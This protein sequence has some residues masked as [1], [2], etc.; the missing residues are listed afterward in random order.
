MCKEQVKDAKTGVTRD[1]GYA[2]KK[3][4]YCTRHWNDKFGKKAVEAAPAATTSTEAAPVTTNKAPGVCKGIVNSTKKPCTSKAKPGSEFCGRHGGNKGSGTKATPVVQASAA[5]GEVGGDSQYPCPCPCITVSKKEQCPKIAYGPGPNGKPACSFHKGPKK[6]ETAAGK[7][8]AR[9][10]TA[11][12]VVPQT[13]SVAQIPFTLLPR[14]L[15]F[16]GS[17]VVKQTDETAAQ[18]NFEKG[19]E[20]QYSA[21]LWLIDFMQVLVKEGDISDEEM[22][23]K[24]ENLF[25]DFEGEDF[26]TTFGEN[27]DKAKTMVFVLATMVKGKTS[28]DWL[29]NLLRKYS[30]KSDELADYLEDVKKD[31]GIVD[32]VPEDEAEDSDEEVDEDADEVD[33][34]DQ[35]HSHKHKEVQQ[36]TVRPS[37]EGASL[38]NRILQ[39]EQMKEQLTETKTE[40]IVAPKAVFDEVEID[41]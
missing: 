13:F 39:K 26:S 31:F 3:D 22:I 37:S 38:L 25:Y 19:F 4:G 28:M 20:P 11:Q 16:I 5:P 7:A 36:E 29:I 14:M 6:D 34:T 9:P 27:K 10:S 40:N 15:A 1:C 17:Y 33:E 18:E 32:P 41:I 8:A 2:A 23:K 21:A 12:A 30:E 24:L 35:S